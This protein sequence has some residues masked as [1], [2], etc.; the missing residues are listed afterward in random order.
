M[1]NYLPVNYIKIKDI[2]GFKSEVIL[3]LSKI[4]IFY[5]RPQV[6]DDFKEPLI[7]DFATLMEKVESDLN[8]KNY[9]KNIMLYCYDEIILSSLQLS[10]EFKEPELIF[11]ACYPTHYIKFFIHEKIQTSS[12][13]NPSSTNSSEPG[14]KTEKH[15]ES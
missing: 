1:T 14:I 7:K 3:N 10:R 4:L 2:D 13:S 6:F 9:F 8:Y 11:P 15:E 12:S 5:T